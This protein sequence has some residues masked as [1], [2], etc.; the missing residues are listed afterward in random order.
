M[1]GFGLLSTCTSGKTFSAQ[2]RCGD[3]DPPNTLGFPS[4][5]HPSY[6]DFLKESQRNNGPSSNELQVREILRRR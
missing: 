3:H 1:S 5:H 2:G 4:V 6:I